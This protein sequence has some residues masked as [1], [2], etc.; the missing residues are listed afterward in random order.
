MVKKAAHSEASGLKVNPSARMLKKGFI[1][2][3]DG[4][5]FRVTG[6][7]VA[8]SMTATVRFVEDV[9]KAVYGRMGKTKTAKVQSGR[10][11]LHAALQDM[12]VSLPIDVICS[13]TRMAP[14]K[15]KKNKNGDI[16]R[17]SSGVGLATADALFSGDKRLSGDMKIQVANL[18]DAYLMKL[19]K[20][21]SRFAA[22][23]K[24]Q[25]VSSKD[26]VLAAEI[27]RHH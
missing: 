5:K 18:I 1:S 24:R 6:E 25:T 4:S 8:E 13:G 10:N 23:A 12:C 27:L 2:R 7:A 21:A 17:R 26:V 9:S 3:D 15:G 14:V 16:V 19:G 11:P 20:L 22:N